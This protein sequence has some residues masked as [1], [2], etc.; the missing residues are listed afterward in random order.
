MQAQN[1]V[2]LD[3]SSATFLA[4]LASDANL[5]AAVKSDPVAT[6]AQFGIDVDPAD[7]PSTVELP[8]AEETRSYLAVGTDLVW[9][10]FIG[11]EGD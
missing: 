9:R 4:Q 10:P 7:V 3:T 6:L 8:S 1:F 2:S 11:T 5:R